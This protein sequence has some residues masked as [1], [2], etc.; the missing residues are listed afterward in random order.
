VTVFAGEGLAC[1][2]GERAVF[3]RLSFRVEAGGVLLLRGANGSGKSS[4]L[5][6]MAGLLAPMAGS[7]TWDG[8]AV[9]RDVESHRRRLRFLGHLDAVKAA[10][11][12]AEDLAL[13]QQLHGLRDPAAIGDA[14][15]RLG[16]DPL[17]GLPTRLLS[18]GQRRRVALAR[19]LAAPAPLWLLDEPTNALDDDGVR[20]F[21]GIVR[22]H[23]IA[24]G[25]AV[26]AA[27]GDPGIAGDVLSLA[28]YVPRPMDPAA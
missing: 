3:A 28:D 24:G 26:I 12:V 25:I 4:L 8:E 1:L 15:S 19:L 6:C 13:H 21:A 5:R 18:A 2:R 27:H 14:L 10:L 17:A 7:L 20:R 9:L 22:D 23:C 16:I 11:T